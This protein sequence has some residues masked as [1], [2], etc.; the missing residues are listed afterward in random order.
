MVI[1]SGFAGMSTASFLAQA[2]WQVT[3]LEKHNQPGGRARQFSTNGFTF[4]MGPSWYWMPDVF[5][6]YFNQFG[7]KVSDYYELKRLDPSYRIYFKEEAVDVPADYDALKKL[8]DELEP[9]SSKQLDAFMAEAAY[10]YEVGIHK[11][12]HKPGLSVREFADKELLKGIFRLDVFASMKAHVQ[13]HFSDSRLRELMEFPVL[14]LG[15]LP[16]KI[17]AL[18]SLMNYADVKLGTWYPVGGMYEIVKAM[19]ALA[20]ELGVKFLFEHNVEEIRTANEAVAGVVVNGEFMEADVMISGAD[21]HFT[22]TALLNRHDQGYSEA[23]WNNRVMAPS[24]LLYYVGINKRLPNLTHHSLFFDADFNKHGKEI[25]QDP[26]WPSDP[27]FYVSATTVTD[28]SGAPQG[29]ENLF[30]LIPVAAGLQDDT[31]ELRD[32]YF[33]Q[34]VERFERKT[35]EPISDSIVYKRSYAVSDFIEDYNAFKGNAYGLANTLMQTAILK[36]TCKSRK[37]ANLY[38]TGQLTVPGPGVP[39]SLI[40]GEVVAGLVN[41]QMLK[42]KQPS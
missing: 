37:V 39:P 8:F 13:K 27:L 18:Y 2:G 21:Y 6:R 12:V 17:P 16:E 38:F 4:D 42:N 31:E 11:L 32:R 10:K 1:G 35:G 24:C 14:F 30:F 23:Y 25:Y 28:P 9:G 40:S 26:A 22:D 33:Q 41:K 3:V 34:I 36:P 7:K 5:E 19:H 15:A 29:C 20:E